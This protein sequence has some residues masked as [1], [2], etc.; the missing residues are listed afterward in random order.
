MVCAGTEAKLLRCDDFIALVKRHLAALINDAPN[1]TKTG[2]DPNKGELL[3]F[4]AYAH[5]FPAGFLA[6]VDT[7]EVEKSGIV[8]FCAVALALDELGYAAKGIRE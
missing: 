2:V 7:Y 4:C 8:N 1:F 5:A 6:L 3:A